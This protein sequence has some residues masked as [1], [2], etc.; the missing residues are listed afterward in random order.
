MP[1]VK[2]KETKCAFDKIKAG[3]KLSMTYYL[4]VIRKYPERN[5]IEVED[6]NGM[7]F[8]VQGKELIEETINSA[9]QWTESK[10][11]SRTEA[12]EILESAGDTV[13]SVNFNK[14]PDEKSVQEILGGYAI[15]DF[16][17]EKAMKRLSKEI[18]KGQERTL[19]GYLVNTEAKMGRSTV[20]DLEIPKGQHNLRQVDHRTLNWI[21]LKNV[22]YTV[23]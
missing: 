3:D 15:L 6:Q 13:F 23:K 20:V 16:A 8:Q 10:T 7:V 22:K 9:S 11:V 21:I 12:I 5:S 14:L 19:V 18:L 2:Q 1:S 4:N 17:N